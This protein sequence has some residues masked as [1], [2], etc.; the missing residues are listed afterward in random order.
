MKKRKGNAAVDKLYPE[1]KR[2]KQTT[3]SAVVPKSINLD[4]LIVKFVVDSMSPI[5]IVGKESF[6]A[7]IEGAQQQISKPSKIM[8]KN[9]WN[10]KKIQNQVSKWLILYAPWLRFGHHSKEAT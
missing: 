8:Q 6:K 3:L 10:Q 4:K 2:M 9:T 7:L 5:T 1:S